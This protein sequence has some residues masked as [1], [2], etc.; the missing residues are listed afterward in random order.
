MKR[1]STYALALAL[2]ASGSAA[3][4]TSPAAAQNYGTPPAPPPQAPSSNDR[5]SAS[6]S[7]SEVEEFD[8]GA[9]S[10]EVRAVVVAVQTALESEE[11]APDTA[12]LLAQLQGAVPM[13]Q[14]NDDRFILGQLMLQIAAR[15]QNDGGPAE[16]VQ[17]AQIP[18]LRL[19]LE[20]NR[21]GVAQ[22]PVYWLAIGNAANSANDT[23]G[24]LEAYQN[25][26]RYDPDNSDAH[27]QSA[28]AHFRVDNDA[29][30]YASASAA[31]ASLRAAGQ[32]IP[33]SWH[34]VPFR[35]AYETNDVARVVE[36]GT[37][38]LQ[39]HPSPQNWNEVLRVLQTAGRLEEQANLDVLRLMRAT[40]GLDA[41]LVNEYVRLAALRG[42]PR[43]AQDVYEAAVAGGAI[44]PDQEIASELSSAIPGDQAGLAESEAQARSSAAGRV[45]LNTADAYA[46]YGD[47]A[48]ALELYDIALEKGG[49]DAGTVHLRKGALLYSM[50]QMDQ[51]RAEFEA[52]TGDRQ[53]HA[54]FWLQWLDEQAGA[55]AAP[56]AADP[57]SAE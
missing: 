27:I 22:R 11:V 13:V 1:V 12:A 6:S 24:A 17:A 56:A 57:A 10:D 41:N 38:F 4:L 8:P 33:S 50:G 30:G 31:F 26:L 3:T 5:R 36:F 23:A 39:S 55:T 16:Q 37:A 40:N 49:V 20:S 7:D 34:T 48:K 52:V 2:A 28:L 21:V 45:A 47:N 15:T 53:P 9:I 51:A 44:Q 18:G 25:V 35:N 43:E 29:A 32:E 42:L 14:N 54:A 19:G 46:S